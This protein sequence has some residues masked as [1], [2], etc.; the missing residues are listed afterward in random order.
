MPKKASEAQIALHLQT[1]GEMPEKI[2]ALTAGMS[3]AR[4]RTPPEPNEWSLVEILAHVRCGTDVWSYSIY[5]MLTLESP[6]L[7]HIHPREWAKLQ[8]YE[9]L[10]FA[11]NLQAF[12]LARSNLL[13]ILE[14][15][16]FAEWER[17]ATF[18]GKVNTTNIFG[19]MYRMAMHEADHWQQITKTAA[20][21]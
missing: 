3:E 4:L 18:T 15:L 21:V 7:A 1:L 16:A 5:A 19:E 17:S 10:S 13:R 6:Q 9:T 12:T 2:A 8:R 14:G 20:A 11:E